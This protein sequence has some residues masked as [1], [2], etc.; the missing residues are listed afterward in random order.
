[1]AFKDA[2]AS[3]LE[4][5]MDSEV[6]KWKSKCT[7]MEEEMEELKH[8]MMEKDKKMSM[9]QL[10]VETT[11]DTVTKEDSF[12]KSQFMNSLGSSLI[13]V[14]TGNTDSTPREKIQKMIQAMKSQKTITE[15]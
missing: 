6:K 9:L 14:D 4:A 13:E 10:E 15:Q 11:R 7:R 1:L 3:V 12:K 2:H 8:S 5:E